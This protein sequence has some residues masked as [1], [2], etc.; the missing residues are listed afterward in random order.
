MGQGGDGIK[1]NQ[2][3]LYAQ[4]KDSSLY[5]QFLKRDKRDREK[6][7]REERRKERERKEERRKKYVLVQP[8]CLAGLCPIHSGHSH[9]KDL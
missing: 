3:M 8:Q 4:I 6:G 7:G 2:S 1:N 5:I 9:F